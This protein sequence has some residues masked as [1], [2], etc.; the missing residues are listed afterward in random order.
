MI[1]MALAILAGG[2]A[3]AFALAFITIVGLSM[4]NSVP[5]NLL[6][7]DASPNTKPLLNLVD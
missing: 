5:R 1:G 4:V 6:P 3:V 7:N 2:F